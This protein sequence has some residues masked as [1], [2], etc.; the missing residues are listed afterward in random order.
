M[1][2][3]VG[4]VLRELSLGKYSTKLYYGTDKSTFSTVT[5]GIL[6]VLFGLVVIPTSFNILYQTF[7][8]KNYTIATT[9]TDINGV[10]ET[11]KLKDFGQ[12]LLGMKI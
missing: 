12:S 11:L 6:T 8:W 7:N 4:N 3:K 9:Y 2:N 10:T 5:G 1:R